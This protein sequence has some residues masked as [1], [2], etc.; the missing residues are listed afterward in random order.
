MAFPKFEDSVGST[1]AVWLKRTPAGLPRTV[2]VK[3][4]GNSPAGSS[5]DWAP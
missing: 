3:L 5:K 2:L 4:E 1:P